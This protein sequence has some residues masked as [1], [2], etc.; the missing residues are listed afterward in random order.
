MPVRSKW[1]PS[2]VADRIAAAESLDLGTT[3]HHRGCISRGITEGSALFTRP[4]FPLPVILGWS[5][6]PWA[7]PRASNPAVAGDACRGGDRHV[8]HL[9]GLRHHLWSSFHVA[10]HYVR[11]R[12]ARP[13]IRDGHW[14]EQPGCPGFLLPFG[15]RHSLL[16]PSCPAEGL[17]LP[18]GRLTGPCPD[19]YG[20]TTFRTAET[21]P[22]RVLSVPR[23]TVFPRPA[24]GHRPPLPLPSGQPYPQRHIPSPGASM[25]RHQMRVRLRSPVR[26]SP[27]L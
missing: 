25:T 20:V 17:G 22:G 8:G 6:V 16:G 24:L 23:G 27:R 1:P 18:C 11:L 14:R 9:P 3:T 5:E 7:F 10:T 12:V 19:L 4:A 2:T 13:V 26:S 15:H 21:R